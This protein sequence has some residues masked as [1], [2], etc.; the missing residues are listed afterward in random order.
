[1]YELCMGTDYAQTLRGTALQL[2]GG[3]LF[4]DFFPCG[5]TGFQGRGVVQSTK[6]FMNHVRT[7]VVFDVI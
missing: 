6:K 1:M 3:M 5:T 4:E 2:S 7:D